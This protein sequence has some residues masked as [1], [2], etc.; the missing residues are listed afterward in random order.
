[1]TSTHTSPDSRS[2]YEPMG[3]FRG[4]VSTLYSLDGGQDERQDERQDG[5]QDGRQGDIYAVGGLG[6]HA[7]GCLDILSVVPFKRH[8]VIS[9]GR[10]EVPTVWCL[11][12]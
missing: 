7:I 9:V 6:V 11:S 4:I 3:P 10:F 1:L 5:R 2:T 8:K 12:V